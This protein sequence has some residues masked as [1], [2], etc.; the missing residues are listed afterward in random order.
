MADPPST[1]AALIG[2]RVG[3]NR[4]TAM[5]GEGTLGIVYAAEHV[6]LGHRTACKVLRPEVLRQKDV[7]ERFLQQARQV[8]QIHHNNLVD[9]FDIGELPDGRLYYVM[10]YLAGRTLTQ[11]LAKGRL[12]FP[13][14]INLGRQV[15]AGLAAAHAAG[16]V[17]RD[18]SPDNLFLCERPGAPPLVKITNFGVAAVRITLSGEEL[19]AIR[20]SGMIAERLRKGRRVAAHVARSVV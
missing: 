13:E 7:V 19:A 14:I 12:G 3:D 11:T 20:R 18:L 15:C 17:H 16:L 6:T 9:I 10:E 2:S 1:Q 4:I 5:L 8:S